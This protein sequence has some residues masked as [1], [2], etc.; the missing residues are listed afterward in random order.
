M[1]FIFFKE[2]SIS[3]V[4]PSVLVKRSVFSAILRDLTAFT[5]KELNIS[6]ISPSVIIISLLSTT[7][8]LLPVS[9][10]LE[11][12]WHSD[13]FMIQV[14]VVL[15]MFLSLQSTAIYFLFLVCFVVF[16]SAICHR[17]LKNDSRSTMIENRRNGL[18]LLH[19]YT[20]RNWANK[21]LMKSSKSLFWMVLGN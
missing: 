20:S 14:V 2:I 15:P 4:I 17:R 11:K 8:I 3:S 10:L 9:P 18:V 6:E 5:K 21:Q 1:E 19:I 12:K 13:F 7:V 16:F